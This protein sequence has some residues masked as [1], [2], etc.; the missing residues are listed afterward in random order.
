MIRQRHLGMFLSQFVFRPKSTGAVAPSSRFLAREMV[1]CIDWPNVGCVVEYGPG[2][3]VVTEQI[4]DLV[5]PEAQFM[6]IELN[7]RFVEIVKTRFP[8]VLVH[9]ESV[10]N[11]SAVCDKES[12]GRVDA[13]VSGLPWSVFSEDQ[14]TEYLDAMMQ[15]L[16]EGGQFVTFAY[17]QG[18]LLPAGRR[19]RKKL[20]E[21]FGQVTTTRTVW[22]N[23]P[24]AFVYSCRR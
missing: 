20:G 10:A 15:V 24:P 5:R 4:I 23:L 21:Y 12:V 14:Q 19:F 1:A 8:T 17:L 18:T 16:P 9:H 13:V 22:R 11:V 2:T 6:A 7:P 3:G